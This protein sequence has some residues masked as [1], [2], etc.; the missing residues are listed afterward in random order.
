MLSKPRKLDLFGW[1]DNG[2]LPVDFEW[3]AANDLKLD[4]KGAPLRVASIQW[5]NNGNYIA[6]V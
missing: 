3:P 4:A 5:S 6:S 1:N 2:K